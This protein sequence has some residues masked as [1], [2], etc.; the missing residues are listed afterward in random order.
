M[1]SIK[2]TG[3]LDLKAHK[4]SWHHEAETAGGLW[5]RSC[6]KPM[7]RRL[8]K[9]CG[10][11]WVERHVSGVWTYV[12]G[13]T[14]YPRN[15][16]QKISNTFHSDWCG[17]LFNRNQQTYFFKLVNTLLV[18]LCFSVSLACI[19]YNLGFQHDTHIHAHNLMLSCPHTPLP[20]LVP[21]YSY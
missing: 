14:H 5:C 18:F 19:T 9:R 15:K 16:T 3:V 12:G 20:F 1:G 10:G 6:R 21:S 17:S 8:Q 2:N 4:L 7:Y 11:P 13:G